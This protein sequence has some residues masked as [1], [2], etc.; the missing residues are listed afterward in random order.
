LSGFHT[1]AEW[2]PRSAFAAGFSGLALARRWRR[3]RRR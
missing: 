2:P 3:G 1:T